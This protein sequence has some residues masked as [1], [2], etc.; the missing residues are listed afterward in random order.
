M[1]GSTPAGPRAMLTVISVVTAKSSSVCRAWR[2]RSS[3]RQS[4]TST[5][6]ACT[7][8][9][10]APARSAM[11]SGWRA[12]AAA[13]AAAGA[14]A[15]RPLTWASGRRRAPARSRGPPGGGARAGELEAVAYPWE[16]QLARSRHH[17]QPALEVAVEQGAHGRLAGAVEGL[18]RLVEQQHARL[19]EQRPGPAQLLAHSRA[20]RAGQPLGR[21]LEAGEQLAAALRRHAAQAAEQLQVL[22]RG[23]RLV[24]RQVGG[25]VAHPQPARRGI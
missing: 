22:A 13:G 6:A 7:V 25:H 17:R 20:Q 5:A 12:S 21:Q 11:A 8:Q 9:A 14:A 23:E 19:V 1:A 2:V 15:P 18:E 4:L 16:A 3:A 10:R 24:E